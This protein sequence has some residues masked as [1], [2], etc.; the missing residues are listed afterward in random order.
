MTE[1][2]QF[3]TEKSGTNGSHMPLTDYENI[4]QQAKDMDVLQIALGGGNPNQHPEFPEILKL[5]KRKV[6]DCAVIY[7]EWKGSQ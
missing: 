7:D 3:V 1:I 2:A 4:L 5:T 6:W